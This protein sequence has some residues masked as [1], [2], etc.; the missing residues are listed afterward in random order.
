MGTIDL[1]TDY[2]RPRK[3]EQFIAIAHIVRNGSKVAV[4]RMEMHNELG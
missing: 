1:R 4:T 3:G 2:L